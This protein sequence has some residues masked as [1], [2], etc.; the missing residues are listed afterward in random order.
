M[1]SY[2]PSSAAYWDTSGSNWQREGNFFKGQT[3][4]NR[5]QL[6]P[7]FF[8]QPIGYRLMNNGKQ[9]QKIFYNGVQYNSYDEGK[10]FTPWIFS[11]N[12]GWLEKAVSF[13]APAAFAAVGGPLGAA[14]FTATQG[15]NLE[16]VAKS[17]LMTYAAQNLVP[18][19]PASADASFIAADAAQLS[20]QGL[21]EAQVASTL[22][23]SGVSSQAA[24]TA[25]ALAANNASV[26]NITKDLTTLSKDTSLM[27]TVQDTVPFET[28][29]VTQPTDIFKDTT[30]DTSPVD[31]SLGGINAPRIEDMGA[32]QGIQV[33]AINEPVTVGTTP[34]DYSLNIP[35]V[36][37]EGL[38]MPTIPNLESMG[39]GQ[40]L[41]VTVPGGTVAEGGFVPTGTLPAL[42]DPTSFI[43]D[44]TA[45]DK[46]I[47]EGGTTSGLTQDQFTNILKGLKGLFAM[48]A[49]NQAMPTAQPNQ[50]L[51][52]TAPTQKPPTYSPEYFQQ[53]QQGYN[54]LLPNQPKD[55]A[56][57]LQNWYNTPYS[58]KPDSVTAKLFGVI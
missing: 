16:D 5:E 18:A 40:G 12:P 33:P 1:A 30:V 26:A 15:G 37:F 17:A 53:V 9:S 11:D 56:T 28:T 39:G 55:V 2:D 42:G 4:I 23:A 8:N 45:I 14:A 43:N 20:A 38:Q 52:F 27:S 57:P 34:I 51:A 41:S 54:Q 7:D 35:S 19:S 49:I 6:L 58:G 32:A 44:P 25:A 36:P 10:T 3:P 29:A 46:A 47:A 31:Y 50:P 24:A 21:G 13:I 22:A 48:G